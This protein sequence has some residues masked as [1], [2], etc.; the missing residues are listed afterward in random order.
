[1]KN[2]VQIVM[3]ENC[4]Y[5]ADIEQFIDDDEFLSCVKCQMDESG[6]VILSLDESHYEIL[7]TWQDLNTGIARTDLGFIGDGSA[8]IR[9]YRGKYN[10]LLSNRRQW[11]K[12]EVIA[13]GLEDWY[14]GHDIET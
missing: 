6:M 9:L 8:D 14:K 13:F 2:H 5:T 1:M 3:C 11:I 10:Q 7:L 4:G 12:I